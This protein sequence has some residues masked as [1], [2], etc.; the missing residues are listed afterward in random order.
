[1]SREMREN[2]LRRVAGGASD[3]QAR[4]IVTSGTYCTHGFETSSEEKS[5]GLV[6]VTYR[7]CGDCEYMLRED[8]VC[9]CNHT[10]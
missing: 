10:A 6:I 7:C 9:Y 1:M 5:D 4:E 8:G 3:G 2:D